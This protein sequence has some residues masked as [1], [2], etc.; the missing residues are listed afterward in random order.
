MTT[1]YVNGERMPVILFP[2]YMCTE[3]DEN[4]DC[5]VCGGHYLVPVIT[6][7]M[8]QPMMKYEIWRR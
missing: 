4:Y 1:I 2:C 3:E 5:D 8:L 6:I 7:S